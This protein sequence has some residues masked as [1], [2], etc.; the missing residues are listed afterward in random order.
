[1]ETFRRRWGEQQIID[2]VRYSDTRGLDFQE[3]SRRAPLH[4]Y[5]QVQEH[6]A[7][8]ERAQIQA[9]FA[10]SSNRRQAQ[11]RND[12]VDVYHAQEIEEIWKGI[13]LCNDVEW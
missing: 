9:P 7:G 6:V 13:I 3:N 11:T 8:D 2:G 4:G 10:E 12:A 1:M 5:A